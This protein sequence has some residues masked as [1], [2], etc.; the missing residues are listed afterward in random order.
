[1]S[2]NS[3][4]YT[5]YTQTYEATQSQEQ[6]S[7]K[8]TSE[9]AEK[10]TQTTY[11]TYEKGSDTTF[12]RADALKAVEAA[13]NAKAKS[14]QTLLNSMIKTQYDK[15]KKANS[16]NLKDYFSNLQVDEATRLQA[17]QEISEDGYWGVEQTSGRIFD[18]AVALAGDDPDK[19][20]EMKEAV[21]KGFKLAEDMWG[22]SLPSIS[23]NTYDRVM[24]RFD[25]YEKSLTATTE[26]TETAAAQ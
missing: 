2:V 17:Q 11:D 18:F 10:T 13:N 25:E 15:Y 7:A 23:Q 9:K 1:M 26:T 3:V 8:E 20:A 14:M 21:I 22:G 12:N 19:L 24:E 6:S 16:G 5:K 4:D